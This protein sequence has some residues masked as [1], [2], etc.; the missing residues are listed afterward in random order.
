MRQESNLKNAF[1]DREEP[2]PGHDLTISLDYNIQMYAQQMALKVKE[3]K[4]QSRY[5]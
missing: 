5:R 3:E 1:E 2:V 4:G